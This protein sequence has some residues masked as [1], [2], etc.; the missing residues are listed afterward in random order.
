[1]TGGHHSRAV[2]WSRPRTSGP[3]TRASWST[4]TCMVSLPRTM[5]R[6]SR[7][8]PGAGPTLVV[9]DGLF[10]R[11][12]CEP[13]STRSTRSFWDLVNR[14]DWAVCEGVQ[15]GM[16]SRRFPFGWYAPMEDMSLDIRRYVAAT[17]GEDA[18]P[19][20]MEER[21][22]TPRLRRRGR[23][24]R[25]ARLRGRVLALAPAR[26]A[27]ARPRAVRDRPPVRRLARTSAGSS[28]ALPP[29]RLRPP[30]RRAPTTTW[31]EVERETGTQVVFRTGGLDV[32]PRRGRRTASTIDLEVVRRR[33]DRGGRPVRAARR[34]RDHAPL[35]RVAPGRRAH[36]PVPG[37]HRHRGPVARQRRPPARS[38]SRA[39]RDAPRARA[40]RPASRRARGEVTVELEDGERITGRARRSSRRTPGRNDLLAPLGVPLP[41]DGHAG[42]GELVHAARRPRAVRAGPLPGLDLDGRAVVLRLPDA[43]PPGP[44]DRPGRGRRAR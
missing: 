28:G 11:T 40:G 23:R 20:P 39:R 9:V 29:A 31:A 3:A 15:G 1:M 34:R 17:V 30:R 25:R 5:S 32:G 12:R 8:C 27:R 43:R 42:A 37:G 24:A 6:C 21:R 14:Q 19:D 35:S 33:D 18:M 16:T 38:P 4:P 10:H 36:G 26:A 22:V 13:A 2:P 44:Q 7:W 41:A